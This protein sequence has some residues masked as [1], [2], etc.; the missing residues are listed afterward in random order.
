MDGHTDHYIPDALK[1]GGIIK[2]TS[3]WDTDSP[4]QQS[5]RQTRNRYHTGLKMA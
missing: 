3:P 2:E 5:H 4:I 1:E